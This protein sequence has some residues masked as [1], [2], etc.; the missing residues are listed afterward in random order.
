MVWRRLL[1]DGSLR[2]KYSGHK[3]Y[4]WRGRAGGE[5]EG[6]SDKAHIRPRFLRRMKTSSIVKCPLY[7][8]PARRS[9]KGA[10]YWFPLLNWHVYHLFMQSAIARQSESDGEL[11]RWT[12]NSGL[13]CRDPRLC[14]S[15][16]KGSIMWLNENIPRAVFNFYDPIFHSH[17]FAL[18]KHFAEQMFSLFSYPSRFRT[19]PGNKARTTFQWPATRQVRITIIIPAFAHFLAQILRGTSLSMALWSSSNT[20][21]WHNFA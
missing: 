3:S 15:P 9:L 18:R 8:V 16:A 6:E 7:A 12:S 19:K 13:F 17:F 1:K 2:L 21:S 11:E 10:N 4:P 20:C 14:F 5:R